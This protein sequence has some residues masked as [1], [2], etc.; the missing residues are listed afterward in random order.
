MRLVEDL[1]KLL[2]WNVTQVPSVMAAAVVPTAAYTLI[3]EHDADAKVYAI[4]DAVY[5]SQ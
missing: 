1:I 2:E 3:M 5:T 4:N